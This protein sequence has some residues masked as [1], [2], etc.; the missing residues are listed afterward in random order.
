MIL[1]I[2][3]SLQIGGAE[4]ILASLINNK[5]NKDVD[6]IVL[7]LLG[8]GLLYEKIEQNCRQVF[9]LNLHKIKI[10]HIYLTLKKIKALKPAVIFA[11]M[12]HSCLLAIILQ[13][14]FRYKF[15]IVWCLRHSIYDKHHEKLFTRL[16]IQLLIIYK[17]LA[18]NI[19]YNSYRSK[20]SHE[21][22]GL[23]KIKSCI[24]YN[25]YES[26]KINDK[27]SDEIKSKL[28]VNKQSI[29]IGMVAN[30]RSF[31][32]HENCI[33]AFN[34][35]RKKRPNVF[36]VLIGTG[37]NKDNNK[38]INIINKHGILNL[39]ILVGIIDKVSDYMK[40]FDISI[41][42]SYSESFP[43]VIAESM[44]VGTPVVATDVGA[45]KFIVGNTGIVVPPRSPNLLAK[46]CLDLLD[47][48]K[49]DYNQICEK[50]RKR[51]ENN[52]SI[53]KMIKKFENLYDY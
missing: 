14:I 44:L 50:A 8:T 10:K 3:P 2:I 23:R 1:H 20:E 35:I 7:S 24:I 45:T 9:F 27:Y 36:L 52:F 22:I 26:T 30:F 6:H 18:N 48:N 17:K 41:L 46:G 42:S 12:Y 32:D 13:K 47:L 33:E 21:K 11:W 49:N 31:K 39:V 34:I 38:L 29:I 37:I 51:I 16:I 15:D 40:A 5:I 43:N 25:G 19:I 53:E 4:K 28:Q